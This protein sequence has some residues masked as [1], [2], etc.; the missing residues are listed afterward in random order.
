MHTQIKQ[1]CL[2]L[3]ETSKWRNTN[4][5]PWKTGAL[6]LPQWSIYNHP[7]WHRIPRAYHRQ[8]PHPVWLFI[9]CCTLVEVVYDNETKSY[10]PHAVSWDSGKQDTVTIGRCRSWAIP[11]PCWLPETS[12]SQLGAHLESGEVTPSWALHDRSLCLATHNKRF[13][14]CEP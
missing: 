6:I 7:K 2:Q 4:P 13:C 10:F 3:L 11:L 5:L 9:A 12:L 1:F 14:C 8:Q